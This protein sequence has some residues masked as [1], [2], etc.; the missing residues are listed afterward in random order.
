MVHGVI[1][2]QLKQ[3]LGGARSLLSERPELGIFSW[4][5][6]GAS[7]RAA[8]ADAP[9]DY[10]DFLDVANGAIVARIVVFDA[11]VGAK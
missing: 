3:L 8:P 9:P 10:R 5:A 1:S 4:I 6:D 11:A 7:S 2:Q